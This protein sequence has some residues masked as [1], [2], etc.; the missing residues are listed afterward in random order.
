MV[1]TRTFGKGIIQ[2]AI[3]LGAGAGLHV[4]TAKWLT[5]NGIWVNQENGLTPDVEVELSLETE[6]DD[7]LEKAVEVLLQ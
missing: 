6:I 7:Q 1:G 5:P 3:D 2:E 4:T